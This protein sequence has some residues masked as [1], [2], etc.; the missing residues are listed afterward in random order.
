[1]D[2]PVA[3]EDVFLPF[4]TYAWAITG[5][6]SVADK[7]LLKC[8]EEIALSMPDALPT[9]RTEW[10]DHMDCVV[11]DW[12]SSGEGR[13]EPEN[14]MIAKTIRMIGSIQK[15]ALHHLLARSGAY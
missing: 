9:T 7:L 2:Q 4:R 3:I 6:V 1:M 5:S 8:F 15:D 14:P 10:F 13:A 11:V 12:V